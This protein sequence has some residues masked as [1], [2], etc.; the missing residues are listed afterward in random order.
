[1]ANPA[2]KI[3]HQKGLPLTTQLE[4]DCSFVFNVMVKANFI[5]IN[6]FFI[7]QLGWS[8]D[9][10]LALITMDNEHRNSEIE[11]KDSRT[12]SLMGSFKGSFKMAE[13]LLVPGSNKKVVNLDIPGIKLAD[14][15]KHKKQEVCQV[16]FV[17]FSTL[18]RQHHCRICA[19]AVCSSCSNSSINK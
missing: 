15:D 10:K 3:T 4:S 5:G 19:N 2:N 18:T 16:C 14:K 11:G 9:I 12:K 13:S 17:G 8:W 7:N 1:M 6:K